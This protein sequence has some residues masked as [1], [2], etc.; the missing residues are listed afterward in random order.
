LQAVVDNGTIVVSGGS[1]SIGL[2]GGT[3]GQVGER[4]GAVGVDGRR[5]A[6]GDP[7]SLRVIHHEA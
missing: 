6:L 5:R 2:L 1:L 7:A 4:P 3:G